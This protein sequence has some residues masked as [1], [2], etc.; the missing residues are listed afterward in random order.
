MKILLDENLPVKIK[1][2][3]LETEFNAYTVR[4]MQWLG[5]ENGKLLQLMLRDNFTT[6]VT[7][8]NNLSFQQNFLHY[9]IQV[10]VLIAKDN[11]YETIMEFFPAIVLKVKE[12]YTGAQS[13]VHPNYSA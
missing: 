1:Y 6:F 3:F 8:D 9:P 13:V 4:D 7:I 2:R 12:V 10:V 5:K 11:I